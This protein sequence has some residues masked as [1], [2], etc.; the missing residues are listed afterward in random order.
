MTLAS[1]A[2]ARATLTVTGARI[3]DEHRPRWR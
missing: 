3:I 2:G 1:G